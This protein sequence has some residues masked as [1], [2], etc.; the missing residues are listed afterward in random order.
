MKNH[1][2][3]RPSGQ[4]ETRSELVNVQE[5]L[6]RD[7]LI[8]CLST[9][10]LRSV[11]CPSETDL[12]DLIIRWLVA[13]AIDES[14]SCLCIL[15]A[16]KKNMNDC[17]RSATMRTGG[18]GHHSPFVERSIEAGAVKPETRTKSKDRWGI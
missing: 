6:S 5:K 4:S 9:A 3:D 17:L 18:A 12:N 10:L 14:I 13:E 16:L 8:A 2:T 11:E 1:W 15:S 7:A